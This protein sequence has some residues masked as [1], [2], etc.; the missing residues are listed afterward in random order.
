MSSF[1]MCHAVAEIARTN[2]RWWK[3]GKRAPRYPYLLKY[4]ILAVTACHLIPYV[5]HSIVDSQEEYIFSDN[6]IKEGTSF[7]LR[8]KVVWI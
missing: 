3:D 7:Q 2:A 8:Y 4:G 1:Q 6:V 5:E